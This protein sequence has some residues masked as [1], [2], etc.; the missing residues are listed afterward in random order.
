MS[1]SLA[2]TSI[3]ARRK[4]QKRPCVDGNSSP[5]Q[6]GLELQ[7]DA[8]LREESL[9]QHVKTFISCLLDDRKQLLQMIDQYRRLSDDVNTLKS[10]CASLRSS[11]SNSLNQSPNAASQAVVSSQDKQ[12]TANVV[13]SR[14]FDDV[15]RSRSLVVIGVPESTAERSSDRIAHDLG[16]VREI[17][18]F[19]EVDCSPVGA[20]QPQLSQAS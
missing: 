2:P 13:S 7:A 9:P 14:N 3:Q 11:L 1:T 20:T 15:E 8:I 5:T 19:L 16:A 4:P 17:M 10:E 6:T 18:D 12:H